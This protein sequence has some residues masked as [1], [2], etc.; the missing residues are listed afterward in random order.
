[1]CTG[2]LAR[3]LTHAHTQTG[4]HARAH[5]QYTFFLRM[6]EHVIRSVPLVG[7]TLASN[8]ARIISLEW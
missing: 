7:V 5:A 2:A 6:L 8:L 1:M 3:T 4:T